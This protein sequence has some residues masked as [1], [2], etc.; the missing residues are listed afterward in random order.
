MIL[1]LKTLV[2][3]LILCSPIDAINTEL[4]LSP[5]TKEIKREETIG[6][7]VLVYTQYGTGSGTV[8]DRL[9]RN[10]DGVFEYRVLTNEHVIRPRWITQVD[11]VDFLTG[12]TTTKAVDT[13]CGVLT[14]SILSDEWSDHVARVVEED[15]HRDLSVLS[16]TSKEMLPVAKMADMAQLDQITIFD[17]VV[18]VGCKLGMRPLPTEGIISGIANG[19]CG[20]IEWV[21]YANTASIVNGSSGGGLFKEYDG[22]Y[23]LI[24]VPYMMS[25][26]KR[27]QIIPHMAKAI[28]LLMAIDI[29][30]SSYTSN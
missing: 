14:F 25:T 30:E 29:I 8:I 12:R 20:E 21:V 17:E 16:F 23:Y 7:I 15:A 22:H 19:A 6:P 2:L 13:G 1:L 24:G 26:T 9:R 27:G 18:S 5:D 10:D 3:Y 4:L 11:S 28:S